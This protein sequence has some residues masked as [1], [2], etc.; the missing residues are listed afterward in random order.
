MCILCPPSE[1]GNTGCGNVIFES[2]GAKI[3]LRSR[4]SQGRRAEK[5]RNLG[6]RR[7]KQEVPESRAEGD[8]STSVV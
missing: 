4:Q 3:T 5:E 1:T 6:R 2:G 7:D 8:L